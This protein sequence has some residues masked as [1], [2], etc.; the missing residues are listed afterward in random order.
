[1][2]CF[3]FLNIRDNKNSKYYKSKD[4]ITTLCFMFSVTKGVTMKLEELAEIMGKSVDEVKAMLDQEDVISVDLKEK[5]T[6]IVEDNGM[7]EVVR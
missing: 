7:I 1:M 2:F 4:L 5:K 3:V 6:R